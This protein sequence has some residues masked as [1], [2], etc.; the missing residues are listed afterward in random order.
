VTAATRVA[1]ALADQLGG[2]DPVLLGRRPPFI[3]A[4]AGALDVVDEAGLVAAVVEA[5]T[6]AGS[7]SPYGVIVAR[8]RAIPSL[9]GERR[10]VADE[11]TEADRWA[12]VDRAAR[13]GE[14]L[15]SLVAR[16]LMFEDEAAQQ[17]A[18]EFTE[19]DLRATALAALTGG[20]K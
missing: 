17:V 1:Q 10:Q 18:A 8:I 12:G 15:R 11:R 19:A 13:R 2:F 3:Q 14:T 6:L 9:V 4:V 16:G 7:R 20:P 5:G